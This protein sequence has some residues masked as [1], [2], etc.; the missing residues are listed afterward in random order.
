MT[1]EMFG[2][3][4]DTIEL[5]K[6]YDQDIPEEVNVL[7]QELP[8]QWNNTKKIAVTVKQQVAPLQAA[9]VASIRKKITVFDFRIIYYREF[10]K[11][12]E[13]FQYDCKEP[14]VALD[15]TDKDMQ[16]LENEMQSIQ[17][18][19]SLFEVSVPEFKLLKQ[20]RKELK[21][22]KVYNAHLKI[23]YFTHPCLFRISSLSNYGTT[24][25]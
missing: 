7:L 25:I 16:W 8:E 15:H 24:Y 22:L 11:H 1:D 10:F 21:M 6:F 18:S 14:Y 17:E 5:L 12:Y 2:P 20:C 9:E 23:T 3:L 19:G 13:F 4:K